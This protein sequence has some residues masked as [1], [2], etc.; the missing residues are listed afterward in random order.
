MADLSR[1]RVIY[2]GD[3]GAMFW[4]P[5]L[6]QPEGGPYSSRAIHS[7]VEHRLGARA[8]VGPRMTPAKRSES[9]ICASGLSLQSA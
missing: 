2:N 6:W 9:R 7:F 8:T 5:A 3:W 1:H 4:S